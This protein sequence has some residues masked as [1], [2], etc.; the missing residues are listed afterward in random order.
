LGWEQ[1]SA[2]V[3]VQL[4]SLEIKNAREGTKGKGFRVLCVIAD[5]KA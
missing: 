5:S 3:D 2:F 4:M 1:E